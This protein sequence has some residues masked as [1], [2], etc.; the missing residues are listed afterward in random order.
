[1]TKPIDF[2]DFHSFITSNVE[3]QDN[4]YEI[5]KK[6]KEI[7]ENKYDNIDKQI[8]EHT[9]VEANH[10]DLQDLLRQY[11][12]E[13]EKIQNELKN[14][15][16]DI[17]TNERKTYYT[18]QENNTLD[19]YYYYLLFVYFVVLILAL[20]MR[21]VNGTMNTRVLLTGAIFV[22]VPFISTYILQAVIRMLYMIYAFLPI[23]SKNPVKNS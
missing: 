9:K 20:I 5:V 10:N 6:F 19:S 12:N 8:D 1:M 7:L 4:P 17:L 13:N 2:I 3:F 11:N 21:Y 14:K 22:L 15:N 18:E 16:S 23:N